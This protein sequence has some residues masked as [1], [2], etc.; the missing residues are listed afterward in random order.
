M[1]SIE[2]GLRREDGTAK[3]AYDVFVDAIGS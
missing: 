1:W 2:L 3:P